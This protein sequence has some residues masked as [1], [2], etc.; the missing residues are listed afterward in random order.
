MR[1]EREKV[2]RASNNKIADVT[3]RRET[4]KRMMIDDIINHW[5]LKRKFKGDRNKAEAYLRDKAILAWSVPYWRILG[6]RDLEQA[7][8]LLKACK[9]CLDSSIELS[10]DE[11]CFVTEGLE[12]GGED[13][14]E[15]CNNQSL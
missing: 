1:I 9:H 2:I 11:A 4:M 10:V 15:T 13:V 3:Q 14:A 12:L 6:E 7:E 5:W 8:R